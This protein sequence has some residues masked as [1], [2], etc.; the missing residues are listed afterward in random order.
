MPVVTKADILSGLRALGL[1]AGDILVV[2]SALSSFGR[3][4]GGAKT[5]VDALLELVGPEGTVVMPT[6]V[7]QSPY[8]FRTSPSRMGAISEEFRLRPE[9]RR[10]LNPCVPAAAIGPKAD[11]FTARH[12]LA[13]SPYF[14][15]PYD[16]AAKA[17]GY[18]LLLGVDQDRNTTLHV[19]EALIHAPYL[20]DVAVPYVDRDGKV[21][22]YAGRWAAGPHR[23]FIGIEPAL[24]RAGLIRCGGIGACVARLMKGQDLLDFCVAELRK[25]P[26]F[27]LTKNEGYY[28]GVMQRGRI[29]AA[30]LAAKE[31]FRLLVRTGH[32]GQ[33]LEET[34][35]Q[36]ERAG[37]AGLE[38]DLLNGVDAA[39]LI[40]E[41]AAVTPHLPY[42]AEEFAALL[43]RIEKRRLKV[44]VV[45]CVSHT[46]A[47][48]A[49]IL[50]AGQ[51]LKA[52]AILCPLTGSPA[53][54]QARVRTARAAGLD[55]L[56]ENIAISSKAAAELLDGLPDAGL[57]FN[58]A[59]FAAAGELPF[60]QSY[61][62][63]KKR[64]RYLAIADSY[65][66]GVPALPGAGTG[67][68]KELISILRC[69]SFD[70]YFSLGAGP[71]SAL[72]FAEVTDAFYR[73]LEAC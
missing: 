57:A 17:G 31:S 28:D 10:S 34:L 59:Q 13:E 6:L 33:T 30:Q 20:Q 26:A 32:A 64:I 38:L 67:E 5:V 21:Q 2:H 65:P 46:E 23:D 71:H 1:G 16:L 69:G 60:L 11:A 7:G 51:A 66:L 24:R 39:G 14:D 62:L 54:L 3:V 61:R 25:D 52:E 63:V 50:A 72:P 47:A 44:S 70:G 53:F 29:R 49:A 55:I 73:L 40:P 8:D 9:A 42:S 12:H 27:F 35:T 4:E 56:F 41:R 15:S 19:A 58:P 22:T 68:V 48:F 18:V 45:R 36:A 37:A 43:R